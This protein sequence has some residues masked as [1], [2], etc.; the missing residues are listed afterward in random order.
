MINVLS[1]TDVDVIEPFPLTRLAAAAQ[2]M[3]CYKTMVFGDD[4]P[5]TNE[6]IEEYLKL[7]LTLP[8]V[9]SWAIVDKN[10]LTG[11]KEFESPLVGIIT[12][13]Q[14]NKQNA[15]V[16]V[17]SARR[18]WGNKLCEPGLVE[19]GLGV[20]FAHLFENPSLNRLSAAMLAKNTAAR[21]LAQRLGF[22]KDGYFLNMINVG[23]AGANIIH[24]GLQR[25]T[26]GQ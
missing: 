20:V 24:M 6:E 14:M 22:V 1:G 4:G 5:Q 13:E 2:W 10:N 7:H 18:A 8:S 21:A 26:E 12:S 3:R 11:A 9:R 23:G 17:A 16:H 25:P 15:Y 19:Q